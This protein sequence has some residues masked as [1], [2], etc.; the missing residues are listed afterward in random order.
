MSAV[1]ADRIRARMHRASSTARRR[2]P[3]AAAW[4]ILVALG[5]LALLI[6]GPF[7][8]TLLNAFKSQGDYSANG[9]LAWPTAFDVSGLLRYIETVN[10]GQKLANSLIISTS[11]A[12]GTVALSLL[13]AYAIGIGRVRGRVAIL[14]VLL[15][16]NILPQEA[17]IYPLFAGVQAV[18]GSNSLLPI[19]VILIVLHSS[20]GT[21]LL[22]S[23]LGTF[24]RPLI[25]AAEMDGAGRLRVLWQVVVPVVRPTLGVLFIFVFIW[26]WN[27][28]FIPILFLT[29]ADTQTVPIALAS[30][31]GERFLNPTMTAA[32]SLI[33]LIPTLVLFLVFQRSLVRGVTVGS[34]R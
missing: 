23:V 31:Q 4:I 9:P 30:L 10:F 19:I 17:L 14:A 7:L 8:L 6:L 26:S 1:T 29:S 11:V 28:F 34:I 2:R 24:P 33:S 20:F 16:A 15:I 12:L 32:G 27:E 22:A 13:G 5:V 3:S 21:Y 25:E 18:N